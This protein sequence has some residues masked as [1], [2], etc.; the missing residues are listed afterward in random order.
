M[1]G[2]A[3]ILGVGYVLARLRGMVRPPVSVTEPP[4]AIAVDWDMPVPVRDGRR[5]RASSPA[6]SCGSHLL[7]PVV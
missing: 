5:R 1:S 2:H 4:A 6:T 7:V 3:T